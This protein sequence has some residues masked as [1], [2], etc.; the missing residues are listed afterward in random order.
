M[1]RA[2]QFAAIC[3]V[4]VVTASAVWSATPDECQALRKHGK[5]AEAQACYKSLTLSRDPYL[6][7]E[8]DW[9][10]ENYEQANNEFRLAVAQSGANA[11]YRVRWGML[12]HERF[13]NTDAEGLFKEALQRDPK[14]ARAYLGL[15]LVSADGF[16]S[17]AIE[18]ASD[19]LASDPKL[20]EAHELMASLALE[21]SQTDQ[22]LSQADEAIRL[23]PDALDAMAIHAAVEILADRSP[24]S[25]FAKIQQVNPTYGEAYA[26][27]A[28]HLVLN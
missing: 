10:L 9:G 26:I 24:D 17:K 3:T 6:R 15:A 16:D 8:G 7:A 19:A 18:W 12:L 23:S 1:K 20:V 4:M 28:H 2:F 13:N 27:V 21:D 25:W 5:R 11:M 14:N 22:A